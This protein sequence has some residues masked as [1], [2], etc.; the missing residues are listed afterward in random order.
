MDEVAS[1]HRL[2]EH[3]SRCFGPGDDVVHNFPLHV[4]AE[5]Y[6]QP[7]LPSATKL[8]KACALFGDHIAPL[9]CP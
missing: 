3:G 5:K 8:K 9:T 1:T 6:L 4:W 7:L 2:F